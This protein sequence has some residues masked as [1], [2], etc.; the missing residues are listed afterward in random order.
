MS[1]SP[2]RGEAELL[3]LQVRDCE[4]ERRGLE[5]AIPIRQHEVAARIDILGPL[6]AGTFCDDRAQLVCCVAA[7]EKHLAREH[8]SSISAASQ[9]CC[10]KSSEEL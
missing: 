1:R 5:H 3:T 10:M 8:L 7:M 4:V 6:V 2:S 9:Q